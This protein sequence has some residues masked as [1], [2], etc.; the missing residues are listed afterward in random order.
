MLISGYAGVGK[1]ALVLE[2]QKAFVADGSLF[3]AGKFD[4]YKTNIPYASIAQALDGLVHQLL[5]LPE[6]ELANWRAWIATALGRNGQLI[7]NLVP[8]L[9]LIIGEQA[10]VPAADP[11][12]T[13]D[14]FHEALQSFIAVFA[15]REQPLVLFIDDLQWVDA[16]TLDLLKSFADHQSSDT[17]S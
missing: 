2:A 15:R 16:A 8:R 12:E 6:A 17:C 10:I 9:A 11:K 1:S 5:K 14:R 3:A 13:Q 4:Q 7:V